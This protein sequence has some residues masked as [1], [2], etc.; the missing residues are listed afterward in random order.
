MENDI[1][2]KNLFMMCKRLN[3]SA[4]SELPDGYHIR[5][6]RRCELDM[7]KAMPFDDP[8]TAKEY[9]GFMTGFF[10]DVYSRNENLFFEKCLFVCD[11]NDSPV[12]TC[13]AWR[14]YHEINTIHWFKIRKNY[15]GQGIGRALLSA[16]MKG[17]AEN[18]YP[19]F[20]HTHPSS[21]RAIKLYSDF[22]FALLTDPII[23]YRQNDLEE[24]LPFLKA[25][26]FQKDYE[27]LRFAK[28]PG[29]FLTAVKSSPVN[30]F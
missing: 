17:I 29:Y 9:Y 14:S 23:G 26:M 19:V 5:P 20:L 3:D 24:S 2:D 15:E 8:G 28:A 10:E 6:C 25:H 22:G 16:V 1:P 11:K 4:V 12:G 18:D 27:K 7:W 13:F 21:Y 30:Q